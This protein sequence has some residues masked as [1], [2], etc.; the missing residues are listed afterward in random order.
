MRSGFEARCGVPGGDSILIPDISTSQYEK[1]HR[2]TCGHRR[3]S[4][5]YTHCYHTLASARKYNGRLFP[6]LCGFEFGGNR[7]SFVVDTD[8]HRH[9]NARHVV[10]ARSER[11]TSHSII[12]SNTRASDRRDRVEVGWPCGG[13]ARGARGVQQHGVQQ[14]SKQTAGNGADP[15]ELG[16]RSRVRRLARLWLHVSI[17]SDVPICRMPQQSQTIV[18]G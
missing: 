13:W 3:S 9:V 4:H 12:K 11:N 5:S 16:G 15:V 17:P 1:K 18:Q 2:G 10:Q 7:L 8:C 6:P 14:T